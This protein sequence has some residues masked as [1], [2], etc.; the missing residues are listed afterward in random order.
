[1][2]EIALLGFGVVGGGVARVLTDNCELIEKRAKEKISIKYILD[3]RDFPDSPFGDRI[4]HDYD[5]IL[6]DPSVKIVAEMMGGSH[7]AY[8]YT[9]AALLAGKSVVTSNK[10]CVAKFGDELLSIA[11]ENGVRYLFEASV[12]GGIPIIRPMINDLAPNNIISVSGILNGTTNYILTEMTANNSEFADVLA[13][14]QAKGYAERNP[15]A[16]VEGLDA[17]RKIVILT[18]LA[19]GIR[20]DSDGIYCEGITEIDPSD[21]A[22]AAE[23]GCK[24]KLIARYEQINGKLLAMVSPRLVPDTNP[25]YGVD[26][27]FNGILVSTDML[28]DVM[29]YGRGAGMLPT[30]GAVV[31]DIIDIVTHKTVG[32]GVKP[33]EWRI[34]AECDSVCFDEY[35]C[36]RVFTVSG[37]ASDIATVEKFFGNVEVLSEK[38]GKISFTVKNMSEAE[39]KN[40]VQ[41]S[42]LAIV[43]KFR[44]L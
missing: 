4:V 7:P 30:A 20:L 36:D 37:A 39:A 1:M 25:L 9:K 23:L 28:G 6:N 11:K 5:V 18:A 14:A 27:V 15:A 3:L 24:I 19:T 16:D 12:G 34:A 35:R 43:N 41:S 8:E 10:E 2:T 13:D 38:D 40:A 29:F 42:P 21:I 17:A 26:D 31:A 44:M 33:L 22:L 32:E